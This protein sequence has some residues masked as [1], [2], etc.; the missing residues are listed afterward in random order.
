[1]NKSFINIYINKLWC[2][3]AKTNL[4]FAKQTQNIRKKKREIDL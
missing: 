2:Q 1:M 3:K 4:E